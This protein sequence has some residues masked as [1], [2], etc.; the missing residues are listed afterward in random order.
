MI[1]VFLFPAQLESGWRAMIA[2]MVLLYSAFRI[3]QV[4]LAVQRERRE[5]RGILTHL[6]EDEDRGED[7][8]TP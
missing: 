2:V 5:K 8:K 6:S 4:V 3:G 7:R 1:I